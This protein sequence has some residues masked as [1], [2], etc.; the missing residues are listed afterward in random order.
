MPRLNREKAIISLAI[1]K[2][3]LFFNLT[4]SISLG[5]LK[6]CET[7]SQRPSLYALA[8]SFIA[9]IELPPN[10]KKLLSS[11][12]LFILTFS[13]YTYSYYSIYSTLVKGGRFIPYRYIYIS[14]SYYIKNKALILRSR[15]LSILYKL[16]KGS[17]FSK[18]NTVGTIQLSNYLASFS[19]A[20]GRETT[21]TSR[22]LFL[23]TQSISS[24]TSYNLL[25]SYR[26]TATIKLFFSLVSIINLTTRRITIGIY[27]RTQYLILPSLTYCLRTLT[28]LSL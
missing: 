14:T 25:F 10:Q 4:Q 3:L 28:Q 23:A 5:Y 24:N 18:K 8:T 13:T 6:I 11:L 22:L 17:C 27:L 19:S 26:K 12:I 9:T 1:R 15:F 7:I 16:I 20:L 2:L 21:Y